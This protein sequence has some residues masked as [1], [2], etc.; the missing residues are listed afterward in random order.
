M[1][2]KELGRDA[3]MLFK[4]PD[5]D[6]RAFWMQDTHIPLD[7][8]FI[9]DDGEIFQL[10]SMTPQDKTPIC[11]NKKCKYVL[12]VNRGW[13]KD[14]NLGV[15]SKVFFD[16]NS[17]SIYNI[18]TA[19]STPPKTP[20]KQQEQQKQQNP[21]SAKGTDEN[22]NR[23]IE[24]RFERVN[25]HNRHPA[26]RAKQI[27]ML[28]FYQTEEF[29]KTLLPRIC[30]GEGNPPQFSF[31]PGVSGELVKLIDVSPVVK[32]KHPNGK[33]WSCEPGLKTF[34]VDN[35]LKMVEILKGTPNQDMSGQ[36]A[37]NDKEVMNRD[38]A[39]KGKIKPNKKK[40]K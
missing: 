25:L 3:G 7:I 39:S 26:N 40:N 38:V 9:K 27:D 10:D 18:K 33:S 11:S 32:G 19:Q 15:G 29:G 34:L 8:A 28:I 5:R 6:Y 23:T 12:E 14:N 37:T 35:I 36:I 22:I 1:N 30:R 13:F 24:Q 17:M 2:R 21:Q 16:R 4:F 31:E 20:P